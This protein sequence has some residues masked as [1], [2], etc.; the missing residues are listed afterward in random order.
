MKIVQTKKITP[1]FIRE[2]NEAEFSVFQD[3]RQLHQG[4]IPGFFVYINEYAWEAFLSHTK[5][6]YKRTRHEGQGIFLGKYFKDDFGEFAVATTYYE[7]EGESTHTYVGMSEQCLVAISDKCLAENLFM[8]IWIHTHPNFGTFYSGTDVN[9]LKTNFHMPFQT[10]IVVDIINEDIKSFKV[11]GDEVVEFRQ[12]ALYN[13]EKKLLFRPYESK[14]TAEAG[15]TNTGIIEL[16]KEPPKAASQ[17]S[18]GEIVLDEIKGARAELETIKE[19]FAN[20]KTQPADS[21]LEKD[22]EFIKERIQNDAAKISELALNSLAER[23]TNIETEI[24]L[25]SEQS[26]KNESDAQL[27]IDKLK[28]QKL[29]QYVFLIII[30]ALFLVV[31]LTAAALNS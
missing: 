11:K 27:I 2:T 16:K 25:V 1:S 29:M 7:G 3:R 31:S 15:Q 4:E 18:I 8:L 14:E 19:L 23:L 17:P 5:G 21:I 26:K 20:Q 12:Y 24:N 13:N 10:G 28:E 30:F 22:I 6:I 9:C